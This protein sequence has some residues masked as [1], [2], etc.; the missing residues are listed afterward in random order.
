[1]LGEI[2]PVTMR[3]FGLIGCPLGHSAS[4]AYF[5]E[6]FS[7]EG[8]AALYE[9]YE[10]ESIEAVEPLRT[11][12][13]GFNVTIP[14]KKAII[15]YLASVSSE[16]AAVGAV[17]CVKVDSSGAMHGY[18]TDVVGIRKSLEGY[19]LQGAKALV[20]GTGGAA[21][22]V[23]YVLRQMGAV[24]TVV[25]R[26]AAEGVITYADITPQTLADVRIVVNA[27]PVGMFPNVD[28]APELPYQA[29]TAEHILFDIVYN[30]RLTLFLKR[31]AA[32]G[33]TVITGDE[34]FRRQA[35]ASW[36]IWSAED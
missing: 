10:L 32:Q 30:P 17:N 22:A 35:E 27:T 19:D 1:M 16:A 26:R 8:I 36:Q 9:P 20:L 4:A 7:R 11:T 33:A 24:V 29:L 18:N 34:M 31:G 6:K 3:K 23:I 2:A 25:S 15:P 14:Y 21:A 13:A 28:F 5:T 12:L